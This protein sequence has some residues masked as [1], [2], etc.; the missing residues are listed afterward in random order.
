MYAAAPDGGTGDAAYEDTTG[1]NE[2]TDD[3]VPTGATNP[4][5]YN[6]DDGEV[7]E[8]TLGG[9]TVADVSESTTY[10]DTA[11]DEAAST[12][13]EPATTAEIADAAASDETDSASFEDDNVQAMSGSAWSDLVDVATGD[14]TPSASD[15]SVNESAD[16]S[17]NQEDPDE[18]G[19]LES[20]L[21]TLQTPAGMLAVAAA[22]Y[23]ILTELGVL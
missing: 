11:V 23:L 8:T 14:S 12:S 3:V 18:V 2:N 4:F 21:A 9:N 13:D 1:T 19:F 17:S 7:Q 5:S 10:E 22:A 20:A 6:V 15:E 16:E